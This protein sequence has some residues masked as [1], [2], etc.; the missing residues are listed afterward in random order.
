MKGILAAKEKAATAT[1][2]QGTHSPL[3][4]KKKVVRLDA[5]LADDAWGWDSM[6][7]SCCSG[8]RAR[9]IS[10]RKCATV[11]VKVADGAYV[12]ATHI[13]SVPLRVVTDSGDVVRI[14]LN[15]VLYHQTF[16]SNLL[17]SELL[18]KKLGWEHHST[19]KE[20]YVVTP[21]GHRVTL[22][23]RGRVAVLMGAGPERATVARSAD[24]AEATSTNDADVDALVRLHEKMAHRG[25]TRMI[26]MLNSG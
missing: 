13:G 11:P 9:F 7:S 25:W 2:S 18:T 21:C 22:S 17:S 26:H 1:T 12:Y 4:E 15:N 24:Q 19:S 23:T 20:T 16:S 8:N 5:A 14:V 3:S 6:A 10:L